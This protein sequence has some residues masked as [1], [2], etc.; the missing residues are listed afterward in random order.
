MANFSGG[1]G[2]NV[3]DDDE[4]DTIS[5]INDIRGPREFRSITFSKFKVGEVK[6]QLLT[7]I[8]SCKPQDACYWSAEL[9]CAGHFEEIWETAIQYLGKYIH[10]GNPKLPIY[11]EMRY[12]SYRSII[13]NGLYTS[14]LQARNSLKIRKLFAEIMCVLCFS[15]KKPAFEYVKINN[16]EE[17][18]IENVAE[19]LRAPSLQYLS[20]AFRRQDPDECIVATNEFAYSCS[21][22]DTMMACYWM[23]WMIEFDA[24]C[25]KRR[26]PCRADRRYDV[27]VDAR[28]QEDV[29]WI[30]W[31]VI[32]A[33]CSRLENTQ[34][35]T[36][37]ERI[38]NSLL[39]LFCI[40]YTSGCA[41]KRRHLLYFAVQLLTETGSV[42]F[43]TEMISNKIMIDRI[44]QNID[45]VYQVIKNGEEGAN[46]NYL[47]Q[48]VVPLRPFGS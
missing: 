11:L 41:K 5:Y 46:M 40:N 39:Q 27:P 28:Y 35:R 34:T 14:E 9:I 31:D 18:D 42:D 24:V 16:E 29:I 19:K 38:L 37:T 30:F 21:V 6:R 10:L 4:D 47:Y 2:G 1:D 3:G 43:R 32:M 15:N 17:F 20:G 25:K 13:K 33:Q 22:R 8:I 23:E 48:G 36:L 12:Q 7:T 26:E 44:L 45:N